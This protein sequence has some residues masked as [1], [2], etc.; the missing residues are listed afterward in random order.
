M[1]DPSGSPSVVRDADTSVVKG[2]LEAEFTF[3]AVFVGLSIGVLL[4]QSCSLALSLHLK[5]AAAHPGLDLSIHEYLLWS[6]GG[7]RVGW[8][9]RAE[10]C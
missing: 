10:S 9:E 8:A 3:R 6:S 4:G 7:S 2:A 1:A 5:I